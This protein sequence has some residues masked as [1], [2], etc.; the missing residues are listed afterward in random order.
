MIPLSATIEMPVSQPLRSPALEDTTSEPHSRPS[1]STIGTALTT[2]TS[3][4]SS[5]VIPS[6]SDVESGPRSPGLPAGLPLKNLSS[7]SRTGLKSPS[8]HHSAMAKPAPPAKSKKRPSFLGTLFTKEPS[9]DAFLLMQDQ[10]RRQT[11][12]SPGQRNFPSIAGVSSVKIP[13][14]VPKVNSKWDG[15]PRRSKEDGDRSYSRSNSQRPSSRPSSTCSRSADADCSSTRPRPHSENTTSSGEANRRSSTTNSLRNQ[16]QLEMS[17]GDL[18]AEHPRIHR[19][20]DAPRSKSISLRTPSLTSSSGSS[21]PQITCFFPDDIPDPPGVPQ[22]YGIHADSQ[23]AAHSSNEILGKSDTPKAG[24]L[25]FEALAI[26]VLSPR[27]TLQEPS[28]MMTVSAPSSGQRSGRSF[29]KVGDYPSFPGRDLRIRDQNVRSA[30]SDVLGR[31]TVGRRASQESVQA[32]LA[33]EAQTL[34]LSEEEQRPMTAQ[35]VSIKENNWHLFGTGARLQQNL[36]TRPDSSRSRLGLKAS[37]IKSN[38]CPPWERDQRDDRRSHHLDQAASSHP[39]R[40]K[41]TETFKK[42]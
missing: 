7:S 29:V 11:A 8:A 15:M 41:T 35:S 42:D 19:G 6:P 13:E 3:R 4:S 1:K 14:H 22:M 12:Q 9:T 37:M 24:E 5:T 30:R 16:G 20:A 38:D 31:P 39:V 10:T 25:V 32:F 2:N 28:P 21:L 27:V 36:E 40:P 18:A 23:H 34:R 33:G 26:H 17:Q